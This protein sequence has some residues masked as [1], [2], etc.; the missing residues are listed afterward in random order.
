MLKSFFVVLQ[1]TVPIAYLL[2]T[3]RESLFIEYNLK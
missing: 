3:D 1:R 2:F